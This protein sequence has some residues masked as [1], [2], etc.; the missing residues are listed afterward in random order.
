MLLANGDYPPNASQEECET[1]GA[2]IDANL[3]DG[4][5]TYGRQ[6]GP[7]GCGQVHDDN[8]DSMQGC[9]MQ[10][11]SRSQCDGCGSMLGGYRHAF[12]YWMADQ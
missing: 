5:L 6:H 2:A 11:F 8:D 7:N 1:L 10:T 9:E 3:G 12:T 4:T